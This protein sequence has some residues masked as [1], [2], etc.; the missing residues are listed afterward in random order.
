MAKPII[1]IDFDGVI[2][3]YERGAV[4]LHHAL[5]SNRQLE[6]ERDT[7][8]RVE[9][10]EAEVGRLRLGRTAPCQCIGCCGR[11]MGNTLPAGIVCRKTAPPAADHTE[12]DDSGKLREVPEET[13]EAAKRWANEA[14]LRERALREALDE[15]RKV[16][17]STDHTERVMDRDSQIE[18]MRDAERRMDGYVRDWLANPEF[19]AALT[20]AERAGAEKIRSLDE[21]AEYIDI[22]FDG[23]P[24]HESGRFVEVESPPGTSISFGEWIHRDDGYWVLRFNAL[25]ARDAA[26][27]A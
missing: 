20:A 12:S 27:N 6:H 15:K 18:L 19:R 3:S 22:V 1:C 14:P 11:E 4:S 13:A 16:D 5:E 23:P 24:S 10:L 25:A 21:A 2:H 26:Q 7:A 17:A 8:R 9:A